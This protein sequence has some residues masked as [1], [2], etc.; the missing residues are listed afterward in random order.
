MLRYQHSLRKVTALTN[1]LFEMMAGYSMD[2][3][4]FSSLNLT[5]RWP[6]KQRGLLR[7]ISKRSFIAWNDVMRFTISD[8]RWEI[9]A[10][11][12]SLR[13]H[14]SR[15]TRLRT[16]N[17]VFGLWNCVVVI[18]KYNVSATQKLKTKAGSFSFPNTAILDLAR[19]LKVLDFSCKGKWHACFI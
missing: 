7:S 11:M 13:K 10:R 5:A 12:I 1:W 8:F 9:L 14:S 18:E 3:S 4:K 19:S 15:T 2:P 16:R 6:E 17:T